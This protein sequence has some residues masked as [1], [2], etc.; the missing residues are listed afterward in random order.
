MRIISVKTF[1]SALLAVMPLVLPAQATH[2]LGYCTDDLTNA[3]MIGVDGEARISGAIFLPKTTMQRYKDGHIVGIR[4]A[5][6]DGIDKPSVWIRTSLNESSKSVQSISDAVYGWNEVTLNNPF[7]IDGSGLYFGYSFTQPAGVKGVLASGEDEGNANTSLLAIDNEWADY[8]TQGVGI[9]YIQAIVE[10]DLP[11]H[12]LGVT[13]MA[14]DSMCYGAGGQLLATA[15]IE[16]LGQ[17]PM[18]GYTLSW[19]IDNNT[20]VADGIAYGSLSPEETNLATHTFDLS[21]LEEGEHFAEVRVESADDDEQPA[22]NILRVPF[23]IYT[24][25]YPR[26]VLLEHFT[27]LPCVNCPPVDKLLEDVVETRN[28]VVWVSHHVGYRNDEFTIEA[29]EPYIKF[30]VWGNPFIMLDR[31]QFIGDT[32]A[33]SISNFTASD[34][35]LAIDIVKSHPALVELTA[36]LKA[37]G[38]QLTA[39]VD[40][41][42][43]SFFKALYPRAT[44]NVFI[45]EDDVLAEGS[46][47]GDANKKRHD[48][49][50]RA[51]LTRSSGDLI[52][53][54]SDTSF[55]STFTLEADEKWDLG[56]L[57]VVAFVT[58]AAD[59]SMGY[60]T[61]QVLN[62]VQ[63]VI[64]DSE[65][66][67]HLQILPHSSPRYYTLGGQL[68]PGQPKRS[69]IYIIDIDAGTRH[70]IIIR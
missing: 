68:L 44:L 16:S 49:I 38:R 66:I 32:P 46:Q 34:M 62:S 58:A 12:D 19:N 36:S 65:T 7:V 47:A 24:N 52:S 4:V 6:R 39:M 48:N 53:W 60:P 43:K 3:N 30:G 42:T 5:L 57:R 70:K 61:G 10:A 69:G 35:N 37:D 45:E 9:L 55:G 23:Y 18:G 56:H 22:N 1:I 25:S 27:S 31:T 20:P 11:N 28:D 14:T 29:S 26:Q 17:L 41:V 59:R 33:F 2:V 63:S 54:T 13:E 64:D 67:S 21:G 15:T 50:T 51:I 8:H 40:G